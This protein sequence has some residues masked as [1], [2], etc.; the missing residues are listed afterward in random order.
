MV[1]HGVI[2]FPELSLSNSGDR[3]HSYLA[4]PLTPEIPEIKAFLRTMEG[5]R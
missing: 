1:T 3:G 5:E 4:I 2:Q